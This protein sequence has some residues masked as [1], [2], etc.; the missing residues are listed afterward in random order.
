MKDSNKL[1]E[2]IRYYNSLSHIYSEIADDLIK[3]AQEIDDE[4]KE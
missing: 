2:K 4:T 1:W 3:L